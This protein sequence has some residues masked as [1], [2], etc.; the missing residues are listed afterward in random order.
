MIP[1][2]LETIPQIYPPL[3]TKILTSQND[4]V[5]SFLNILYPSS[6]LYVGK[7]VHESFSH[8]FVYVLF[9]VS[10]M[11]W[12]LAFS[13]GFEVYPM[14]K[15]SLQLTDDYVNYPNQSFAKMMLLLTMRWLPQFIVYIVDMSIWYAV[16]QGVAGTAVGFSDNLGDIRSLDDIRQNFG[17]APELFCK[18]MLSPDAGSRRGSSASLLGSASQSSL[19]GA[20]SSSLLGSN[21]QRLQS[22]VNRLLDV[23]IQKWVMCSAAWNEIIDCFR[24]EDLLPKLVQYLYF[25]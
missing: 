9:W 1:Y 24:V 23:R 3:A 16:W 7:E 22:Y 5:Q 2:I 20:E 4:Y 21:S 17:R 10:M 12:K 19:R 15:P 18:K 8:T 6:R 25:S 14:V 11:T 13:Y